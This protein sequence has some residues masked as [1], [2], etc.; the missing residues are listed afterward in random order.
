M[1][2]YQRVAPILAACS[3]AVLACS[4]AAAQNTTVQLPQFGVAIN[5]DGVL[6]VRRAHDPTGRLH[7]AR[8]HEAKARLPGDVWAKSSLRKISLVRLERL[9]RKRLEAGGTPDEAMQHLAGLQRIQYV[10]CYPSTGDIVIAGPAEGWTKDGIGRARGVSTF[11]PVVKLEDLCVALRAYPPS[12][13]MQ[14]LI[15]CSIDPDRAG[16]ARMQKFQASVPRVISPHKRQ[17]TAFKMVHGIRK[18]LG[19]AN[20]RVFG[21]PQKTHFA[22]VMIEADYRMKR[23]AIGLEPPPVKMVTYIGALTG[24]THGMAQRWWL[25]P[26]YDCVKLSDD[27]LAMEIVGQGVQLNTQSNIVGPAGDLVVQAKTPKAMKLFAGSFTSRYEAISKVEPVFAQL[28]NMVDLAV[29]AAL[30]RKEN[31]YGRTKW[32]PGVLADESKIATETLNP[33]KQVEAAVNVVWKGSRLLSPAGGGVSVRAELALTPERI[34]K[35]QNK[36]LAT[37]YRG[38]RVSGDESRWWWD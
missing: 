22:K 11:A 5:A 10:F 35:D 36:E 9:I 3:F 23:I 15:G 34:I 2:G 37:R 26:G 4:D 24:G 29:V 25:T 27:H 8:M 12:S 30:L 13:R 31:Y 33:P 18:A 17:E 16:L 32:S 6:E 1:I 21:V 19:M 7:L 38:L 14:P 20:I 28:R